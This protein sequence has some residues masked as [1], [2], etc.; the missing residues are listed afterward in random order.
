MTTSP[1]NKP[2]LVYDMDASFYMEESTNV[3]NFVTPQERLRNLALQLGE[4]CLTADL[5]ALIA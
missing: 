1:C 4:S 3:H 5:T 2:S